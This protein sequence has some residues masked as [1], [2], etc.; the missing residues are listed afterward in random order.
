MSRIWASTFVNRVGVGEVHAV[1]VG[2]AAGVLDGADRRERGLQPLEAC[3]L[4]F[5]QH[6]R[7]AL[8]PLSQPGGDLG[9]EA[10]RGLRHT[11]ADQGRPGRAPG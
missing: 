11:G 9:L 4:S 5:D 7:G 8:A 6:R 3:Q 2:C 1:V 10:R